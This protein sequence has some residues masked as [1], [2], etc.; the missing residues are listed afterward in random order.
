MEHQDPDVRSRSHLS[1]SS[2]HHHSLEPPALFSRSADSSTTATT[3]SPDPRAA[4]RHNVPVE[5]DAEDFYKGYQQNHHHHHRDVLPAAAP[6]ASNGAASTTRH[7][8]LLSTRTLPTTNPKLMSAPGA[9]TGG[10]L[11]SGNISVKDLKKRFDQPQDELIPPPRAP[12]RPS[13]PAVAKQDSAG[14]LRSRHTSNPRVRTDGASEKTDNPQSFANRMQNSNRSDNP[15][16]HIIQQQTAAVASS[17]APGPLLFGEIRPGQDDSMRAGHGIEVVKPEYPSDYNLPELD[18]PRMNYDDD[19]EPASPSQWYRSAEPQQL[20]TEENNHTPAQSHAQTAT[21]AKPT[22]HTETTSPTSKL[23]L[24]TRRLQTAPNA[25]AST[26]ASLGTAKPPLPPSVPT[27]AARPPSRAKTP[28]ARAKT[29]THQN[30]ER[31]AHPTSINST[32]QGN[33]SA[34]LPTKSPTTG[35][36]PRQPVTIATTASSRMRESERARNKTQEGSSR[37]RLVSIGPVDFEQRREHIRLAYTRSIR[38]SQA[39]EAKQK[40]A[41]RREQEA[42]QTAAVELSASRSSQRFELPASKSSQR[43]ELPASKSAQRIPAELPASKSSELMP[44]GNDRSTAR[45]SMQSNSSQL[46]ATSRLLKRRSRS[47][48]ERKGIAEGLAATLSISTALA[49]SNRTGVSR[50]AKSSPALELPGSFPTPSS[51]DLNEPPHS[52]T[53]AVTEFDIEPQIGIDEQDEST[54]SMP[55]AVG[56]RTEDTSDAHLQESTQ[57]EE[58]EERDATSYY[59]RH[60]Q[61]ASDA[62]IAPISNLPP[63]ISLEFT[64]DFEESLSLGPPAPTFNNYSTTVTIIS[65]SLPQTAVPSRET[66]TIQPSVLDESDCYSELENGTDISQSGRRGSDDANTDACTEETDNHSRNDEARHGLNDHDSQRASTCASS[67]MGGMFDDITNTTYEQRLHDHTVLSLPPYGARPDRFSR[68][69]GWTEYSEMS[70][71]ARQSTRSTRESIQNDSAFHQYQSHSTHDFSEVDDSSRQSLLN[72]DQDG[73]GTSGSVSGSALESRAS[74]IFYDQPLDSSTHGN[75]ERDSDGVLSHSITPQSIDTG[76]V[77]IA[78]QDQI[79]TPV[80]DLN[81]KPLPPIVDEE[82]VKAKRRL[83]QRRNVI[84]ELVDTEAIFVRDMSIVEEIYKGTAE[85][86][87]KLDDQTVKLIFRN[88][89][90]IVEFHTVFLAELKEAVTPIYIPKGSR[91]TQMQTPTAD[92]NGIPK[93]ELTP[94]ADREVF[95][96]PLFARHIENMKNV[97]EVF[98][99]NSDQAVK[100][101]V[102]IQQDATVKV[103]LSECNEVAKDLTAAWDLDSLLI[104][105]MQRITKYPNLILTML[106]HT[107]QDHPDREALVTAKDIVESSILEINKTKKNFELV[108]QIVGR[109]R[110][111]SDVKTGLARAFGKRVDKLQT[112]GVRPIEDSDY[113]KLK[114]KFGDDYLRLQ[115]VLRDVEFYTRQ[116]SEYCHEFLQYLSSIELVMRLQP[117]AYPELESKWVQFNISMRDLEKVVLDEHVSPNATEYFDYSF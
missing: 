101:L 78:E 75:S 98:L 23:P 11:P 53:S 93:L 65:D 97:H 117:G 55:L 116:V 84:K 34:S 3:A 7:I 13:A 68:Q 2:H 12:T 92:T 59:R 99:R 8:G 110:R 56:K 18:A 42:E 58:A 102:Q 32:R 48:S 107:S 44:G 61:K 80:L 22:S 71:V 29:P 104:K 74:S 20:P 15:N 25:S 66:S 9:G 108:G 88:T 63:S 83:V 37:R 94:E 45:D 54:T 10:R 26:D 30:R 106:Q 41:D 33:S 105:P 24:P 40:A 36:R 95:I 5:L 1:N 52:A 85:A 46:S 47:T 79:K 109:K 115:V 103:W 28:T 91:K 60:E 43:F 31:K 64:D 89:N 70:D 21:P 39:F 73:L 77:E 50:S 100:R 38:E 14:A 6:A 35:T 57:R 81:S 17:A 4:A 76:S 49:S 90:E 113:D 51:S 67:D 27:G 19:P 69:S 96:G 16:L 112:A 82:A 86:C 62:T 72:P 111:D 114:E 87:P